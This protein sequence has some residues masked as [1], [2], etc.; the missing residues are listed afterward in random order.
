MVSAV[1]SPDQSTGRTEATLL[2]TTSTSKLAPGKKLRRCCIT[3]GRPTSSRET[4]V[5]ASRVTTTVREASTTAC[6]TPRCVVGIDRR[7]AAMA[8]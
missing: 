1:G 7:R 5:I 2:V 8:A 3:E 6:A 4:E